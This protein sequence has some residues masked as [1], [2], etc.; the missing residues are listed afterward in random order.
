MK[1]ARLFLAGFIFA[2]SAAQ[3][4]GLTK[5]KLTL[6]WKFGGET[7]HFLLAKGKGYY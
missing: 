1:I 2:A 4:Q 6:D 3:A 5:V 7:A